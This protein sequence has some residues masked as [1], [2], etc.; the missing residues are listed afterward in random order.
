MVCYVEQSIAVEE[1]TG[2]EFSNMLLQLSVGE[3]EIRK[4][5]QPLA[6]F[7]STDTYI[8]S[9]FTLRIQGEICTYSMI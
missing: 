2:I 3:Y 7:T 9:L 5:V 8:L 6:M 4:N 1:I